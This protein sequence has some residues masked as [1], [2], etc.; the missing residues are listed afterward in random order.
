MLQYTEHP[1]VDVGAAAIAAFSQKRGPSEVTVE[2]LE[3]LA[4]Y[5]E[6]QYQRP[7]LRGY[8]TCVCVP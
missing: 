1:L 8:L 5:L 4:A 6:E 3:R 7:Y 2:D